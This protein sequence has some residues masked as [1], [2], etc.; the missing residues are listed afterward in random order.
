MSSSYDQTVQENY[1]PNIAR[2]METREGPLPLVQC[3]V[4]MATKLIIPGLQKPT[5]DDDPE[6]FEEARVLP[7]KHVIG[8]PCWESWVHYKLRSSDYVADP[9]CPICRHPCFSDR[10][11]LVE[12]YRNARQG[13]EDG[14]DSLGE[15][16]MMIS[17]DEDSDSEDD[18]YS[19]P[20]TPVD[21]GTSDAE[22]GPGDG[23]AVVNLHANLVLIQY[24]TTNIEAI[25]DEIL[26]EAGG[27]YDVEIPLT[28]TSTPTPDL[29]VEM[30]DAA[31]LDVE[32]TRGEPAD[33]DVEMTDAV[34]IEPD[35]A[36][37][38]I[39]ATDTDVE[40]MDESA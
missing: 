33:L 39:V 8:R 3:P 6:D 2:Y 30:A 28:R 34:A 25:L 10:K 26:N 18:G 36:I 23:G 11:K 21:D 35:V 24:S 27:S 12:A 20:A 15:A 17:D 1:I 37:T 32:M 38:D 9:G 22:D 16:P 7:C 31:D 29:D 4:C 13:V 14:D 40:M 5:P 19:T